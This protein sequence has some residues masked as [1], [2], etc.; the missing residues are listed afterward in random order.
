LFLIKELYT[1]LFLT[2]KYPLYAEVKQKWVLMTE[3]TPS[4]AETATVGVSEAA[5]AAPEK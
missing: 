3:E 1:I 2:N 5:T 4:G